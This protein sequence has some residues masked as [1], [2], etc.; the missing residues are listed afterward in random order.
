MKPCALPCQREGQ[1]RYGM[2][3]KRVRAELQV[4]NVSGE[5]GYDSTEPQTILDAY[6]SRTSFH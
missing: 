6:W 2:K 4:R 5:N 3:R 1:A